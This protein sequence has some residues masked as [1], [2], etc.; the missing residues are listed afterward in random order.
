MNLKTKCVLS[1]GVLAVLI[2][3]LAFPAV[4]SHGSGLTQTVS[5]AL[6]LPKIVTPSLEVCDEANEDGTPKE[7]SCEKVQTGA[8]PQT[9]ALSM[10]YT[11][12]NAS[13]LPSVSAV[14]GSAAVPCPIAG[15][16]P[17]QYEKKT[18]IALIAQEANFKSGSHGSLIVNGQ[19]VHQAQPGGGTTFY[20][21]LPLFVRLCDLPI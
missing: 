3:T 15:T 11:L 14:A 6:N 8:D 2:S 16:S 20:N 1:V 4:A 12:V 18:G 10:T 19:A 17:T 13:H 9:I 21:T 5:A 7:E